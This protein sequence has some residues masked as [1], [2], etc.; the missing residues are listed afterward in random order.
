MIYSNS[1]SNYFDNLSSY[2][3]KVI[4]SGDSLEF[5]KYSEPITIKKKQRKNY[6]KR[7]RSDVLTSYIKSPLTYKPVSRFSFRRTRANISR[8]VSANPDLTRFLTLTFENDISDLK[9]SSAIFKLFIMRL[10]YEVPN[11]K[12][13]AVP[14]FTKKGRI[15]YHLLTNFSMPNSRLRSIWGHGFVM[16][17][18]INHVKFVNLYIA[19]YISKDLFKVKYFGFQKVLY[20]RN[21]Y[22]PLIFNGF[23]KI[24]PILKLIEV[25]GLEPVFKKSYTNPYNNSSIKYSI[26]NLK[27]SPP[28]LPFLS[29]LV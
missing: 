10:K 6:K 8:L 28:F 26:F 14:E 13:V 19:K 7:S 4:I 1:Y 15:H 3:H 16:I 23:K 21:L 12:Y 11:L 17:N 29:L 5:Y 18:K 27:E 22:R 20:S 9:V 25:F 2:S 24:N